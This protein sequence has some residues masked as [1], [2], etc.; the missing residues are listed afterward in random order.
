MTDDRYKKLANLLVGY[1]T[2][3]KKGERVL[4]D[5]IDVPD[6]F[7]IELMRAVRAAGAIPLV[8]LRHTRIS[9]EVVLGTGTAHATLVRDIEL[10]RMKKVQAYIA[11]RGSANANE[12]ADV[13]SETMALYNRTLR[14]LLNYRVN[15]TR[16]VVLRWPSPSMAQAANMSTE[17]FENFYFNV[18]T[19]DYRKMAKAMLPLEKRMKTADRV[20]LTGPDTDISFSIKGI[21][22]KSCNGKLNVP[23][24]EVFSCPVKDSVNGHIR[25]NTPT[26]YSGTRFENVRLTFKSG[27]VT[28]ATSNNTKRLNEILNTDAGARYIGEFAIGFNPFIQNPMCD[29]LF[30]EKIAGSLHFTPG[31][32]YEIADNGNRSAV[33]WDMVLIQRPEWG[34]GEIWFDDELIRR[35]GLFVPKDL[36]PLNP[37]RLR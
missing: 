20:R 10:A 8:E 17:A 24:G 5:M 11:I 19:M 4:L 35:D 6:D 26:L 32:A 34:G 21:G 22:A 1:S 25:F 2:E 29:I 13:P 28:E 18:C 7:T 27:K 14:P 12:T 3:L 30:D 36:T 37:D 31:Q 15:K 33:H 16:W 23:D 9:R